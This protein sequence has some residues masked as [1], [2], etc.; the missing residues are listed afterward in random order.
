MLGL[1]DRGR[2]L[3]LF[4]AVMRGRRAGR[5]RRARRAIRRRR[6]PDGGAARP[7]RGDALGLDGA[8]SRPRRPTTRPSAPTSGRAAST[9]PARLAMRALTRAW[10]M[11]LK[12]LE[13]VAT[14]PN[15]MMAA[16]MAII[17]LTHV[18]ELPSPE[19]LVRRLSERA[20]AAGRRPPAA[21]APAPARPGGAARRGRGRRGRAAGAARAGAPQPRR[22]S[23]RAARP[24]RALRGRGGADPRP[25]RRE[26]PRR[27]R[28]GCPPGALRARPH[29]VRAGRRARRPTSRRGWR[30]GCSSGP[31]RAGASRW[32]APAAAPT[33]AEVRAREQ[34]DLH[35]RSLAHPMVQA[36]LAA[37]PGAEIRE[38]RPAD[39]L[40]RRR[41][42][43][44][45]DEATTMTTTGIRSIRSQRR[46]E[47]SR[48]WD[49]LATWP[50][51]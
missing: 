8:S 11:L 22:R 24:L 33:I 30:S 4:E 9:S 19:E 21:A 1:A 12:A 40:G 38:V 7:R 16:E 27:D 28:E 44:A 17:R 2:V 49:S 13:E 25:P 14:A 23:R 42:R 36:V 39:A 46:A 29:R 15:A 35:A 41:R 45:P 51:S 32:S 48:V 10:Q 47:C 31:A 34:G 26:P 18:A 6:R 3:D 43:P 50:R 37:F 5:A 20:A